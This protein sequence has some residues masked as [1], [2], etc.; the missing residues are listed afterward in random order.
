MN[1]AFGYTRRL[2]TFESYHKRKAIVALVLIHS[3][4]THTYTER[5]GERERGVCVATD[6]LLL[7]VRNRQYVSVFAA[8]L[9]FF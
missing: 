1:F 2:L 6:Y 7:F 3:A 4:R 9:S 8:S 5:E